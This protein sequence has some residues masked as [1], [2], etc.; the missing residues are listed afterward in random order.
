MYKQKVF[1]D[2][3]ASH[4]NDNNEFGIIQ[5]WGSS[6]IKT[7]FPRLST[8][9]VCS[10]DFV[11]TCSSSHSERA[12]KVAGKIATKK[13]NQLSSFGVDAL[14]VLNLYSHCKMYS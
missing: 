5:F 2:T 10:K 7:Q 11:H 1:D 6:E 4:C 12:L 14:V 13:R 9:Q 8:K 3:V